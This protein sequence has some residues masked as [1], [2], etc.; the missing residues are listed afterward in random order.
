MLA[1]NSTPATLQISTIKEEPNG[2]K[3]IRADSPR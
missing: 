1:T 2:R 3:N